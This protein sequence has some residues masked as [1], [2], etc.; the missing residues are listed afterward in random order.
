MGSVQDEVKQRHYRDE[1]DFWI[2]RPLDRLYLDYASFD[3][4][5]LKALYKHHSPF[6]HLYPHISTESKRYVT[7]YGDNLRPV[8]V[9]YIEHGVLPQEILERSSSIKSL[10]DG[11][12]TRPCGACKRELHQDSF[13][14][15]FMSGW[16]SLSDQYGHLCHTCRTAKRFRDNPRP[17]R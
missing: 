16:H 2:T 9:W 14:R 4:M 12:G 10:Y 5:L 15:N 6:F 17:R 8:N 3:I 11:M 13:Q 7:L 1:T